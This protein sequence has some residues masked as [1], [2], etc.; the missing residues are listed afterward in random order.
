MIETIKYIPAEGKQPNFEYLETGYH[1]DT[2]CLLSVTR[3]GTKTPEGLLAAEGFEQAAQKGQ[4]RKTVGGVVKGYHS[5]AE[6]TRQMVDSTIDAEIE[7]AT[8]TDLKK[9]A[10]RMRQ[11][12]DYLPMSK[13]F[14]KE[15][16]TKSTGAVQWY[17]DLGDN[18]FDENTISGR[19]MAERAA[20]LFY[21]QIRLSG[22]LKDGSKVTLETASHTPTLDIFV[23][24]AFRDQIENDPV[25]PEG[26][27]LV[28]K[29]G[30]GF[31]EAEEFQIRTSTDHEGKLSAKFIF[32]G[33]EWA[34]N[35]AKMKSMSEAYTKRLKDS[36][37]D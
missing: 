6:R 18:R 21:R 25:N 20:N 37:A 12:I 10:T 1:K 29:M 33:K 26:L 8:E 32:R 34:V 36:A 27:S 24:H 28:D 13:D 23:L 30:G 19:E 11:Q 9:L 17:Y 22:R 5:P 3:H 7:T 35:L 2:E 14:L 31:K 15:W 16:A 4:G